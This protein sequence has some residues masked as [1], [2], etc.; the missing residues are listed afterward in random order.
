MDV[1]GTAHVDD[2][3]EVERGGVRNEGRGGWLRTPR[4]ED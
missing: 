2:T 4:G 1:F 3:R